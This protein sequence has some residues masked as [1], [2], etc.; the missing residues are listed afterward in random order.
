MVVP[1]FEALK[2]EGEAGRRTITKY[3]RWFTVA[4]AT[5]QALGIA[6]ALEA[7]PGLV[8]DPGMQFRFTTVVS[9]LTG[10]MFLMWLG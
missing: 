3:T 8:L 9:L 7:Q 6:V 10:T 2:K 4:L 1:Q 5:F